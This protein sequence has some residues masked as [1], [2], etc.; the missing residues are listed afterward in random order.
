MKAADRFLRSNRQRYQIFR[1]QNG[2]CKIC[3][4]P[5][6]DDFEI[7]HRKSKK[8]DGETSYQNLQA[9]HPQ[10]NRKKGWR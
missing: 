8:R 1:D 9:T 7:D 3:G 5:M 6:T 10:C 4:E 2:R